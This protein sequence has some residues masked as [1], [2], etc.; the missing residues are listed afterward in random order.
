M[1]REKSGKVFKGTE[2]K[3]KSTIGFK[4]T[5]ASLFKNH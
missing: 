2:T 4:E 3:G 5:G 1:K